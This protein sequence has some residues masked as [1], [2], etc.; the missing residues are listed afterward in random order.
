[1]NRSTPFSLK[2][3]QVLKGGPRHPVLIAVQPTEPAEQ[4]TAPQPLPLRGQQQQRARAAETARAMPPS[5]PP[6]VVNSSSSSS[7]QEL[8]TGRPRFQRAKTALQPQFED[9]HHLEWLIR[10][11][12]ASS[13]WGRMGFFAGRPVR[14]WR[15]VLWF[16]RAPPGPVSRAFARGWVGSRYRA[17]KCIGEGLFQR[18]ASAYLKAQLLSNQSAVAA[19][20]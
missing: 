19:P 3:P 7:P 14:P 2:K 11:L 16:R 5:F 1:M 10:R 9:P 6:G 13:I 18:Y 8:R 17:G 4:H 15:R 20:I 12:S